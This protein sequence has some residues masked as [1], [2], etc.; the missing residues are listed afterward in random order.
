MKK[1]LT[2]TGEKPV[3]HR[4]TANLMQSMLDEVKATITILD[5]LQALIPPLQTT[6]YEQLSRNIRNEG[7]REP[8]LIW[9]TSKGVVEGTSEDTPINVLIDG[10]N[11]YQICQQNSLDFK[12]SLREFPGLQA[13]REFMIDNQ[14]GRRNLTPEQL[15][16]LRGLKYR[17]ERQ[18]TGRPTLADSDA[19]ESSEKGQ[20]TREK[21]AKEFNVSPRTIIRDKEF[22]E[23]IDR[24]D[25]EL[26][27]NVLK[28]STKLPKEVVRVIGRTVPPGSAPLS[29]AQVKQVRTRQPSTPSGSSK[30]F[31]LKSNVEQIIRIASELDPDRTDFPARCHE[32][33]T[34][35]NQVQ[36][37]YTS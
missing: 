18:A 16:Y 34:M 11:R 35:I 6:E 12:V 2:V 20:R 25:P 23:G 29:L 7:C 28:G 5:E 17:N 1:F 37:L 8:L 3:L 27:Q 4:N 30:Y 15:A 22:S 36:A 10:H 19:S 31:T 24:L 33:I 14:L 32:L 26:K 21:L 9:Q 13:V